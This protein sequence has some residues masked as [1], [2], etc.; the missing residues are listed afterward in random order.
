MRQG[1][2]QR[3]IGRHTLKLPAKRMNRAPYSWAIR[4]AVVVEVPVASS[5]RKTAKRK[6]GNGP[7][8]GAY[9]HCISQTGAR[10]E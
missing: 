6:I 1:N 7:G 5:V 2:S 4:A 8:H 10:S 9:K 3:E